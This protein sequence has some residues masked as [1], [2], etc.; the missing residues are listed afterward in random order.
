LPTIAIA[1][2][3]ST[4]A[5]RRDTWTEFSM[6]PRHASWIS[7]ASISITIGATCAGG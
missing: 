6:A 1:I 2:T 4:I 3:N 7:T 5:S